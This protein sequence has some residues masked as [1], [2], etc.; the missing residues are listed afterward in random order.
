MT[1]QKSVL[2]LSVHEER[3]RKKAWKTV[4]RFSGVTSIEM[5]DKTGKMTVVGEVDVPR[6]VKKLRKICTADIVSVEIVKPPEKKEE[7]KEPEKPKQPEVIVNPITYWN[8]QYQYHPASYAST[9]YP[10]CGYSRVV[11]EEPR[12]CVIL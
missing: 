10:P 3:I 4:S 1:A 6:L 12:P 9:Y 2:Q 7:K 8:N 11:V 5:D